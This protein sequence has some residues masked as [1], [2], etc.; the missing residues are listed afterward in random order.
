MGVFIIFVLF[1]F[2]AKEFTVCVITYNINLIK[3]FR[4]E[5]CFYL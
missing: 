2:A 5:A 1:F 4:P 3:G